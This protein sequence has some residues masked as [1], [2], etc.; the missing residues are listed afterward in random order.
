LNFNVVAKVFLGKNWKLL[1]KASYF[2]GTNAFG[3]ATV[4][5]VLGTYDNTA[6]TGDVTRTG[7]CK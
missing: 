2:N 5:S 7:A 1:E 3:N 6:H 4:G